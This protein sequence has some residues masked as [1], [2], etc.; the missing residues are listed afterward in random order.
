[1][2]YLPAALTD[3]TAVATNGLNQDA[4]PFI[5]AVPLPPTGGNPTWS[6]YPAGYVANASGTFSIS[7]S[8]D[9]TTICVGVCP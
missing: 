8:G 3:L 9:N 5:G 1:M 4:G 7:A 2:G 6:D